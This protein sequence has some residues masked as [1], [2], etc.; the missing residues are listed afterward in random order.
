MWEN[1]I[2]T[3]QNTI[4]ENGF[5]LPDDFVAEAPYGEYIIPEA[6]AIFQ[7]LRFRRPSQ[8]GANSHR[9]K[10]WLRPPD[11]IARVSEPPRWCG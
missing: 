6:K 3:S 10:S 8:K 7:S 4:T 2:S 5:V 11:R 9:R 1:P